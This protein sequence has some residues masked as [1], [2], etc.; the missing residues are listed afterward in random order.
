MSHSIHVSEIDQNKIDQ[1]KIDQNKIDQN[2][3][4]Q[5]KIDQNKIDQNGLFIFRRDF[6]IVDNTGLNLL[7]TK[8]KKIYTVF[9]FTPEQ[10]TDKNNYKSENAVQFMIESLED[11]SDDIKQNGGKLYSF[12][13]ENNKII[14]H[15]IK[16]L[17]ITILGF[18][19]DY[20]PYAIKRDEELT[21]LCEKMQVKVLTAHDYYL[22]PP[23]TLFNK[24]GEPYQKF[25]PYYET[26]IKQHL[27]SPSPFKKIHFHKKHEI[28]SYSSIMPFK[29]ALHKFTSNNPHLIVYGGREEALKQLN[30]AFKNQKKY[31][32]T[33]NDLSKSTSELSAYIKFGCISIREVFKKF[34]RNKDFVRQLIWRDFYANILYAFPRVLGHSLKPAY[35]KIKWSTNKKYI[36][37]WKNG[38]TGFPIVDAGMR[39]LNK[40]GYMHN[41]AR[42]IV[43]S[44]LVKTL[45]VDWRIGEEYFASKL[46]DYDPASNN[47][48]WQW[49]SGGGADS[50]PYFRIFNPWEQA[51]KHD[52]NCHYI[53]TWV[54][55]LSDVPNKAILN[56][57]TEYLNYIKEIDYYEP[58]IDYAEQKEKT[59]SSYKKIF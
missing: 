11:L 16:S 40:T 26:A 51:K 18:N 49:I 34:S 28:D 55:E 25:T 46:T 27:A 12:Y 23:G 52:P 57:D 36:D 33:H 59:L 56:W 30:N 6:R 4:D 32:H 13:G 3:I 44:F 1:N 35:D 10:V 19:T 39:Q 53:T 47:G 9:I 41:R 14:Q 7:N 17:N 58:I 29:L 24:S 20:S 38:E 37:A 50:Q 45:L 48:N 8:C 31:S 21:D 43:A 15:L 2:K 5:N 22:T 54:K 42:L